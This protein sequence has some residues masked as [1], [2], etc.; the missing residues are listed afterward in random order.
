MWQNQQVSYLAVKAVEVVEDVDQRVRAVGLRVLL[1]VLMPADA[2]AAGV[3]T[4]HHTE[5]FAGYQRQALGVGAGR[6]CGD[7]LHS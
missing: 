3:G 4:D 2:F 6:S 5:R 7:E 1:V